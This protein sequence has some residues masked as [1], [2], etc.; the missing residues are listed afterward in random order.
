MTKSKTSASPRLVKTREEIHQCVLEAKA[1][2]KRIGLVPTMGAL[3]AGHLSLVE[4]SSNQCDRTVVT[5]F[6]N[7]T[8]FSSR[9]DLQNYPRDLDTDLEAL[10]PYEVSWVYA[11][12]IDEMYPPGQTTVVDVGK[13]AEPL[14]G[15]FRPGHFRGVA[16]VVLKLFN[17]IPADIAYF[18][19]KDYQQSLVIRQMVK[20]LDVPIQIRVC[21]TVREPDGLAMSSRNVRLSAIDRQ[22]SL[23]LFRSLQLAAELV[24]SGQRNA[25]SILKKM[26][27]SINAA[28]EIQVDYIALVDPDTLEN[29]EEVNCTTLAAVAATVGKTRLI[30][31][32][33]IG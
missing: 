14:E 24:E 13:V 9:E 4:A 21:P 2:S 29:V 5:I 28:G 20:D 11:P 27:Q 16:T 3:H 30:D 12:S 31:N 18:G 17:M 26:R 33:L 32:R 25:E 15:K 8:Q 22:R 1:Q 7:P 23:A 19:Q 10:S 6:V